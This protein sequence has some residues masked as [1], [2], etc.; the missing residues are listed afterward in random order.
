MMTQFIL[1]DYYAGLPEKQQKM[2]WELGKI[3][4]GMGTK[5]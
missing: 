4:I 2:L 3:E 1:N 5:E